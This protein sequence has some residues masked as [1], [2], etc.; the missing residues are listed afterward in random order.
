MNTT[1]HSKTISTMQMAA[2]WIMIA[3]WAWIAGNF[4][5]PQEPLGLDA[6]TDFL[7]VIPAALLVIFGWRM[8][9]GALDAPRRGGG[10]GYVGATVM[11]VLGAVFTG[12][13]VV[14]LQLLGI[15]TANPNSIGI[16]TLDDAIPAVLVFVGSLLWL[17]VVFL[18]RQSAAAA[19]TAPARAR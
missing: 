5:Q 3:G 12:L 10:W 2:L 15:S 13:G 4:A 6:L 1:P 14:A 18:A 17:V 16:H 19:Q 7:H 11:A 8:V 9:A